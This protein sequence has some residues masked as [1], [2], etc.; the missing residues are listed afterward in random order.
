MARKTQ[1]VPDGFV[2]FDVVYE[3]GTLSSNRRVARAQI[4]QLDAD[5]SA[6]AAIEAQDRKIAEMSGRPLVPIKSV[7]RSGSRQ[8]GAPPAASR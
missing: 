7:T 4:D 2:L 6:Q 8:R 3:D 1:S 5:A